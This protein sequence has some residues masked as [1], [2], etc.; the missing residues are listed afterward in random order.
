MVI[1]KARFLG[2]TVE[3]VPQPKTALAALPASGSASL[4]FL[5]LANTKEFS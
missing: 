5:G 4:H 2:L 1:V 3:S